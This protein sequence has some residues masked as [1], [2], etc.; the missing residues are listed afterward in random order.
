MPYRKYTRY[1][2]GFAEDLNNNVYYHSGWEK[3]LAR[4]FQYCIQNKVFFMDIGVIAKVV[5]EPASFYFPVKWRG[6]NNHYTPDW[7]VLLKDSQKSGQ[8]GTAD[9]DLFIEC[10]GWMD[11]DSQIK[12]DRMSRYFLQHKVVLIDSKAYRDIEKIYKPI[13][14]YWE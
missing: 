8:E 2:Q 6:K 3:N 4:L 7:G 10:K 11:R 5:Y 13:I 1:K 14:P 12:L 9:F